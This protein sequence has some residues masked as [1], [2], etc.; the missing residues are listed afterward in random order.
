MR[1]R[2]GERAHDLEVEGRVTHR[3]HNEDHDPRRAVRI[4]L[5]PDRRG[6][7][8]DRRDEAAHRL[9]TEVRQKRVLPNA[10]HVLGPRMPDH[11]VEALGIGHR[12]CGDEALGQ[13]L[14]RL[15]DGGGAERH[16]DVLGLEH[17]A[18][19]H[20][21]SFRRGTTSAGR[22]MTAM[23]ARA[24]AAI[25]SP[26]VP[27]D[28]EM[29][30]PACPMRRPGGAVWPAMKPITGFVIVC[31]TKSAACCS[32]VPPISPIMTTASVSA[33]ASNAERQ[34]MKLVPM[35]GSP[36]IPMQVDWP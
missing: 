4:L 16:E 26:A 30:A 17:V 28:P 20:S 23:P 14:G 29:I 6:G 25:F 2:P 36:P 9:R 10:H 7:N 19:L 13:A 24:N 35:S 3:R 8:A 33:S 12:P 31:C 27:L 32:S 18:K 22:F 5:P 15:F 34:W 1:Q 21:R 11:G